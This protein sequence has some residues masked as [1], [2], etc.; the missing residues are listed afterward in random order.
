M[1]KNQKEKSSSR[2]I[3]RAL[4]ILLLAVLA[5]LWLLPSPQTAAK[6]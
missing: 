1:K 6:P 4:R 3:I 5:E 2:K